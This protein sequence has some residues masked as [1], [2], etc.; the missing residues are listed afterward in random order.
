MVHEDVM[1]LKHHILAALLLLAGPLSAQTPPA[2]PGGPASGEESAHYG[3]AAVLRVDPVYDEASA[4]VPQQEC[5]EEQVPVSE[6]SPDNHGKGTMATLI[7]AVVGGLLGNQVG[8]GDGRT[9][10]TV[11][12]AVAGGAIGNQAARER[13]HYTT[14]R[15]CRP[16]GVGP[17]PR[18]VVAYD[19]EY[20]YRGEVFTSRVAYDPGDRMR[21]RV[22]V[23][24]A[25]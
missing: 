5:Y 9:A 13:P 16:T 15:H 20:R 25:D 6:S 22:S 12:G 7:G 24:P 11:A 10:A 2:V 1:K 8:K 3:W 14:Q 23:T 18:H 21:V 19:V 17:G 4:E